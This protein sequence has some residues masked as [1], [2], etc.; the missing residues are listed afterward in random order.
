MKSG[1]EENS[2]EIKAFLDD[3]LN[4]FQ[5]K[6][7]DG[8]LITMDHENEVSKVKYILIPGDFSEAMVL[9]K[10]GETFGLDELGNGCE[11][12]SSIKVDQND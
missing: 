1:Y 2:K 8:C 7:G 9:P 10:F 6:F 4:N 5:E 11:L 3:V 12:F